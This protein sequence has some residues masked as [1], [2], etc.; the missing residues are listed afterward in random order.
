MVRK[1]E[2]KQEKVRLWAELSTAGIQFPV[3]I[4]IGYLIGKWFDGWAKT[5]PLFTIIFCIFGVI[6]AFLNIFRLNAKLTR[7][8]QEEKKEDNNEN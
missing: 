5:T 6:A 3:S 4:G 1:K 8:E 7:I 2:R